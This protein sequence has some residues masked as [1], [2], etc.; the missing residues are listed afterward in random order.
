MPPAAGPA[1]HDGCGHACDALS[2]GGRQ[3]NTDLVKTLGEVVDGNKFGNEE[4]A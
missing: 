3:Q 4:H 1:S 2:S